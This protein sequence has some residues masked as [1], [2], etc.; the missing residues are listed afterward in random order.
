MDDKHIIAVY[1]VL[2]GMPA[3]EDTRGLALEGRMHRREPVVC[4]VV[5]GSESG[6]KGIGQETELETWVRAT[7]CGVCVLYLVSWE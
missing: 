4:C 2:E 5:S 3:Q 6:E 7:S 1:L